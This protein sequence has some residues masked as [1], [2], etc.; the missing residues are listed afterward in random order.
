MASRFTA[1][2]SRKNPAQDDDEDE[3]TTDRQQHML[4]VQNAATHCQCRI[5]WMELFHQVSHIGE[6]V[7]SY[8]PE[9]RKKARVNN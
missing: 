1:F 6:R 3:T 7:C 8:A 4:T 2:G 9:G 5:Y